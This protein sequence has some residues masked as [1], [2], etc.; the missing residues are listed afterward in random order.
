[1]INVFVKFL[2]EIYRVDEKR[3]RILLYC[4]SDQNVL[5]LVDFWSKLT[6]IP[7]KQFTKPYIRKDFR[8]DGR[9]NGAWHDSY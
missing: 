9:K 7:K 4:Y 3:F 8:K 6:K 5:E 2:R 1:M